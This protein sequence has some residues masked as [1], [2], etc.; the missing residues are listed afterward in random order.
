MIP[1]HFF[2]TKSLKLQNG[3]IKPKRREELLTLEKL[4]SGLESER[5][6]EKKVQDFEV[7]GLFTR[8]QINKSLDMPKAYSYLFPSQKTIIIKLIA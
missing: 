2:E 4:K 3:E 1:N 6:G 8:N 5:D 7:S